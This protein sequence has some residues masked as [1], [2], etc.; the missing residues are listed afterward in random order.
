MG[1]RRCRVRRLASSRCS[2]RTQLAVLFAVLALGLLWLA[3]QSEPVRRWRS[4]GARWDWVGARH[5]GGRR[6][7]SRSRLRW[8]TP[9]TALAEHDAALE[10]ADRRARE[11]GARRARDRHRRPARARRASRRSRVPRSEAR[12]PAHARVR[13]RRASPRSSCSLVRGRSRARTSPR[14]FATLVVERNLIYLCPDP[15]RRDRA[16]VRRA[17]SG[18][19][20]RSRGAAVVHAVRRR[21]PIAA[22][23]R[24]VPVLRGARPLDRRVREPRARLA[25]GTIES[26]AR[27]RLR[28]RAR[29]RRR[30]R[31]S[32][33]RDSRA[34]RA[35]SPAPPRSSSS[36]GA[37][38]RRSTR[39]TASD[40]FSRAVDSNLPKPYDWVD[41]ATGG[42]SVVVVGQQI[43]DADG[44]LADGVLQPVDRARCGASTAR[45]QGRR[46]DP[47]ARPRRGRRHAHAEPG[48]S[49]RSR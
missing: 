25:E 21:S 39:P 32:L 23:A 38:R 34:L 10:G 29:R 2:T 15:L 47:D 24:P 8:D 20:G 41:E 44:H 16:R 27:R 6:R 42:G 45:R 33:R 30:A 4:S 26:V 14:V 28:R 36:R 43:S 9:S 1:S 22:A 35:S 18:A 5:P 48:R 40:D 7:C 11:L 3:W 31:S 19:A 49:T 37:D 17:A 13:R 12:D 46:P